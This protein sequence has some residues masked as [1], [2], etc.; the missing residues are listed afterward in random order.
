[1]VYRKIAFYPW[2]KDTSLPYRWKVK[3]PV[4]GEEY[5]SN[6]FA[7]HPDLSAE[8][9]ASEFPKDSW[10]AVYDYGVGDEV[11]WPRSVRVSLV[12]DNTYRVTA[13]GQ[14]GLT[15]PK[16]AKLEYSGR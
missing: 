8:Q 9:L 16:G 6:D 13:M 11:V 1:M 4:D 14:V 2:V 5:P 7:K 3:C 15:M 10:F 12:A